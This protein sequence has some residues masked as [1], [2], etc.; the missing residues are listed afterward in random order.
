M[1]KFEGD[2]S[3][4]TKKHF[5]KCETVQKLY[6]SLIMGAFLCVPVI[7][8]MI[9]IHAIF[10]LCFIMIA[11][12]V[13]GMIAPPPQNKY[14]IIFPNEVIIDDDGIEAKSEVSDYYRYIKDIKNIIDYGEYYLFNFY[15]PN[16]CRFFICQKDL[17]IQGTIE[18][19]EK[20]FADKIVRNN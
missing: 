11:I 20:I 4:N 16:K 19:F 15:F 9:Y 1:I 10:A 8:A 17:I 14:G 18:E 7:F 12:F 6:L 5:L 13:L 2:L 3:S